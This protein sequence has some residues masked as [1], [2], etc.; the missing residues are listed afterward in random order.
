VD[1]IL[2]SFGLRGKIAAGLKITMF[3]LSYV[4][5]IQRHVK[6][7]KCYQN[8]YPKLR[9]NT[10]V[11]ILID[12]ILTTHMNDPKMELTYAS[13]KEANALMYYI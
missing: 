13:G 4:H 1:Q 12:Q 9:R 10:G 2:T 5:P 6:H 3:S 8:Y 11:G 7:I